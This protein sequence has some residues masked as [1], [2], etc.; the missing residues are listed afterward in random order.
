MPRGDRTGPSGMGSMTGRA[1]GYCAGNSVPGYAG[2]GAGQGFGRGFN[3]GFGRGVGFGLGFRGGRGGWDVPY[4]AAPNPAQTVSVL[5]E[6][7]EYL[8]N[9]LES[10]KKQIA[11]F[12]STTDDNN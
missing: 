11:G 5:K 1:A 6:Q 10:I 3:R 8:E 12:A 2:P 7:A 4:P 9:T